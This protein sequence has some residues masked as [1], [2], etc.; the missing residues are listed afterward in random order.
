MD[1][2]RFGPAGRMSY[3]M[4][5]YFE[6]VCQRGCRERAASPLSVGLL[7]FFYGRLAMYLVAD[8]TI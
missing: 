5:H 8:S 1:R 6:P 3:D 4:R 2:Q 7:L